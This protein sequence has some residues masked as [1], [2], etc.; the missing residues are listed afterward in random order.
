MCVKMNCRILIGARWANRFRATSRGAPCVGGGQ[1]ACAAP[2]LRSARLRVWT[3]RRGF[4]HRCGRRCAGGIA[5]CHGT[6]S[7]HFRIRGDTRPPPPA[8]WRSTSRLE[9]IMQRRAETNSTKPV[10]AETAR[11]TGCGSGHGSRDCR[12]DPPCARICRA[13]RG[14]GN[15]VV[16]CGVVGAAGQEARG[17][18]KSV[19]P[20]AERD[21]PR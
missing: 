19:H 12:D 6:F 10:C 14:A 18:A 15:G 4:A 3:R 8:P 21:G 9:P 7:G 16:P 5:R 2:V 20:D 11:E 1:R 13:L 17:S